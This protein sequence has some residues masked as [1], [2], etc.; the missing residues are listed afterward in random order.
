LGFAVYGL[1][2]MVLCS[3]LGIGCRVSS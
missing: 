3:V 2:F 1:A